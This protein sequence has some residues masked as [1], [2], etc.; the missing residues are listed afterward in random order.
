MIRRILAICHYNQ[1][2]TFDETRWHSSRQ[3]RTNEPIIKPITPDT[4]QTTGLYQPDQFFNFS[5]GYNIGED[6]LYE[7]FSDC[8]SDENSSTMLKISEKHVLL[9]LFHLI[10]WKAVID[11]QLLSG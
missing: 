3:Q 11:H 7:N 9:S 5:G 4:L 2:V 1:K 8:E 10:I 6:T